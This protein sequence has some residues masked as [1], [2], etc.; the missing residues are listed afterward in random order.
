MATQTRTCHRRI[1][2]NGVTL[3]QV[4]FLVELLQ[5]VPQG[6]N[7]L[8]IIRDIGVFHIHPVAHLLGQSLPFGSIFHDLCTA[9]GVV[10]VHAD[11]LAYIFFFDAQF[12]LHA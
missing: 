3:V 10:F 4:T 5:Q 8:V 2:L 12:L 11:F 1:G 9:G 7:I 6:L